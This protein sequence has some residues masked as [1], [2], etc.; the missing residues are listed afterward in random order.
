MGS[1]LVS[2][3]VTIFMD[4]YE[5]MWLNEYN[6]NKPKFYLIYFDVILAAFDNEHKL[7][8]CLNFLNTK[9]PRRTN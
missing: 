3:H 2:V 8:D 6:L 4:F 1:P 9:H 5:S 7:L